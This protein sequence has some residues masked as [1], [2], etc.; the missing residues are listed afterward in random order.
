MSNDNGEKSAY[1]LCAPAGTMIHSEGLTK[2]EEF[3]KAA[4]QGLCVNT[5]R[6]GYN[7]AEA[8]AAYAVEIADAQLAEL[9][10]EKNSG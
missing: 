10:K 5:G 4:M 7:S 8:I 9:A 3:V 6:N 2:R 1:P